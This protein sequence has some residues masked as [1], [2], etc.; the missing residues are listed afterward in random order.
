V[1]SSTIKPGTVF[2]N[3]SYWSDPRVDE[4]LNKAKVEPDQARRADLYAQALK[5]VA[6]EIPII[7]THEMN[8]PTVVNNKFGDVI[9]SALGVYSNFD[10]AYM[11]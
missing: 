5:I 9:V 8:F 7:W 2:T 10:R 11:K 4:L 3:G 6:E 1:H